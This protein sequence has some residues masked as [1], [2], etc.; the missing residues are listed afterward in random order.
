MLKDTKVK[1]I[2][3]TVSAGTEIGKALREA[4]LLALEERRDVVFEFNGKNYKV[5]PFEIVEFLVKQAG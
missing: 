5:S 1:E 2:V 3:L 4:A